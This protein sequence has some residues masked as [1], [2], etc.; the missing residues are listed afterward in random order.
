MT[1]DGPPLLGPTPIEGLHLNSGHG[2]MGWTQ[3]CGSAE[4]AADL[5]GGRMPAISTDGLLAE[6]WLYR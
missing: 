5:L 6:R 4:L 3:A 1:P 2:A